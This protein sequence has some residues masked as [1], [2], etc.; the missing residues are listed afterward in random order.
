MVVRRQQQKQCKRQS[1]VGA[2]CNVL[3]WH[4]TSGVKGEGDVL[5]VSR[6][7]EGDLRQSEIVLGAGQG[8]VQHKHIALAIPIQRGEVEEEG[9]S[10]R[11][12]VDRIVQVVA[13]E[14]FHRE[15]W[16]MFR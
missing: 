14:Q 10:Q 8:G 11:N 16:E 15:C 6:G 9:L 7:C 12:A 1:N 13:L 3:V 5:V 4:F 2:L